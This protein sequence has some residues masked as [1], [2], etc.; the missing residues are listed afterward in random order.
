MLALLTGDARRCTDILYNGFAPV[1]DRCS[2]NATAI[3]AGVGRTATGYAQEVYVGCI[4]ARY[5]RL[6]KT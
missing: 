6:G 2:V 4:H 3:C 1:Y 5:A